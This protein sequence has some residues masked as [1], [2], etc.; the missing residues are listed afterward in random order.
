[1]SE[2]SNLNI[3]VEGFLLCNV[4]KVSIIHLKIVTILWCH[5]FFKLFPQSESK[6]TNNPPNIQDRN[7]TK[8]YLKK[9]SGLDVD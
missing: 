1:M 5:T 7:T 3:P 4:D 2:K 6:Q 8:N 9:C